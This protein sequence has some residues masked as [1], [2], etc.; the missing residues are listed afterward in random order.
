MNIQ[1]LSSYRLKSK[2]QKVA[3]SV[4]VGHERFDVLVS[5]ESSL[6][7]QC[8]VMHSTWLQELREKQTARPLAHIQICKSTGK[9]KMVLWQPSAFG[10]IDSQSIKLKV[11]NLISDKVD[12]NLSL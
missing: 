4:E 2:A 3:D 8:F 12:I 6:F 1:S 11:V 10:L 7:M 5:S 9:S